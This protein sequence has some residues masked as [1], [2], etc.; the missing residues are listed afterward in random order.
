M[1]S[2]QGSTNT[3]SNAERLGDPFTGAAVGFDQLGVVG[4]WADDVADELS[5][6]HRSALGEVLV[7]VP[8]L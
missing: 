1:V 4:R 8:R 6:P 2:A 3:S 5:R 7:H